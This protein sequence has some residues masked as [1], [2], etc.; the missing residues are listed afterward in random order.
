VIKSRIEIIISTLLILIVVLL[1]GVNVFSVESQKIEAKRQIEEESDLEKEREESEKEMLEELRSE[2]A[3]QLAEYYQEYDPI[4]TEFI[5]KTAELS[6]K[7]ND[8]VTNTEELREL[9]AERLEAV[10]DYKEKLI[11]IG[12]VPAPLETFS[13]FEL[14]FIESDIKTIN[15]LL[16]YYKSENYSNF[17]SSALD[18]LYED[19]GSLLRR[20]EEELRSVYEQYDLGYLLEGSS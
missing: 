14:E 11:G 7:M 20:A 2:E 6:E 5:E 10:L 12:N 17:N 16:S 4:K 13:I 8:K 3:R 18:K 15:L 19:T 9:A 1:V